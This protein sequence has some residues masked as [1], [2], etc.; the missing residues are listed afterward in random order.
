MSLRDWMRAGWVDRVNVGRL[1]G[2]IPGDTAT[3]RI[4]RQ[5]R[6]IHGHVIVCGYGHLGRSLVTILEWKRIPTL[7]LEANAERAGAGGANVLAGD[8]CK[9]GVIR[10]A[11]LE[12]ARGV[13]LTFANTGKALKI[14]RRIHAIRP[15]IPV[16][17]Y[18]GDRKSEERLQ[19]SGAVV[20]PGHLE[21]S[22]AFGRQLMA[23]LGEPVVALD[24]SFEALRADNY[25]QLRLLGDCPAG[26]NDENA[27]SNTN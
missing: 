22:L 6:D 27:Q 26:C 21:L 18:G 15:D 17:V 1:V 7:T 10:A 24:E 11:G 5:C 12:R 4:A 19:R 14:Q 13:A 3:E 8:F 20:F 2:W 23:I 16:L 9:P 25:R